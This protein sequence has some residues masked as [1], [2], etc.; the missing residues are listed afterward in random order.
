MA[1]GIYENECNG[2]WRNVKRAR[3][4][5]RNNVRDFLRERSLTER[6][7]DDIVYDGREWAC[8]GCA[9]GFV[10]EMNPDWHSQ[11]MWHPMIWRVI[12]GVPPPPLSRSNYVY[13]ALHLFALR[14]FFSLIGDRT[15]SVIVL[16]RCCELR[17]TFPSLLLFYTRRQWP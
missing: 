5:R 2:R 13:L 15:F 4:R 16:K 10:L 12:G 17:K 11:S 3:M 14:S 7:A 1:K 8:R 9:M 6:Q